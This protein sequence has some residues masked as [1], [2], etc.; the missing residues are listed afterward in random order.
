MGEQPNPWDLLQPQDA[1]HGIP[2]FPAAQ[3][4]PS[5]NIFVGARRLIATIDL[6]KAQQSLSR[7]RS[8]VVTGSKKLVFHL[9]NHEWAKNMAELT[10]LTCWYVNSWLACS[11]MSPR[12]Y[13]K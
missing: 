4:I 11:E 6:G 12:T 5:S 3:T 8:S 7:T 13:A 10:K 2:L 1:T 9:I